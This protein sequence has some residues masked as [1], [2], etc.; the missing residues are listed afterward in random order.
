MEQINKKKGS[1]ENQHEKSIAI[2]IVV[3]KNSLS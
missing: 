1:S 3:R 2:A